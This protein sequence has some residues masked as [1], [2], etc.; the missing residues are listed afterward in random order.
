M[1]DE[2]ERLLISEE[3][4][5]HGISFKSV[6]VPDRLSLMAGSACLVASGGSSKKWFEAVE[7][8]VQCSALSFN[9]RAVVYRLHN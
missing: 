7:S 3:R 8:K 4:L 9:L 6:Q 1:N 2:D 5:L